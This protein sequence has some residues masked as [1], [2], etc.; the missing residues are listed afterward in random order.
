MNFTLHVHLPV[1]ALAL[2]AAPFVIVFSYLAFI[3]A[4]CVK[5]YFKSAL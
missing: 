3:G 4:C 1:W 5:D 2:A